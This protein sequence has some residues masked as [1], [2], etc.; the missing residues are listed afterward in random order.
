M[1]HLKPITWYLE[2]VLSGKTPVESGLA[3]LSE[4]QQKHGFSAIVAIL[5]NFSVSLD[6]YRHMGAHK[7]VFQAAQGLPGITIVDLLG[8]FKSID[9]DARKFSYDGCHLTEIGH[10]AMAEILLPII[11]NEASGFPVG[12]HAGKKGSR[13][14]SF[15]PMPNPEAPKL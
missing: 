15:P 12:R 7:K 13:S 11:K 4:L 10:R 14:G 6:K 9:N 3:L 5:P 2:H 8:S 1:S